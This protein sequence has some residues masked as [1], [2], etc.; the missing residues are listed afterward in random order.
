VLAL[1]VLALGMLTLGM[2]TLG[3]L[4]LGMLTLGVLAVRLFCLALGSA[5]AGGANGNET[6]RGQKQK[7]SVECF[8]DLEWDGGT[9]APGSE[10]AAQNCRWNRNVPI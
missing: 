8:H 4:T 3:M 7:F 5:A 2:L 1:G 6:G 9:G 10:C